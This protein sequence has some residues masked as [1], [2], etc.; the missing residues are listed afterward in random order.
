MSLLLSRPKVM[1]LLRNTAKSISIGPDVA[2]KTVTIAEE[3]M[4]LVV[5]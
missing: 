2:S 1:T 5:S 3:V 4:L